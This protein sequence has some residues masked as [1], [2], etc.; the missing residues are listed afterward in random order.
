MIGN[1]QDYNVDMK[2]IKKEDII[3]YSE[4]GMGNGLIKNIEDVIYIDNAK[5]DKSKTEEMAEEIESDEFKNDE[6]RQRI[7]SD[8]SGTMG[9][10]RPMDRHSC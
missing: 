10:T 6:G 8:R 7:Y 9:N 5:F 2:K 3:L 4:K 1:A